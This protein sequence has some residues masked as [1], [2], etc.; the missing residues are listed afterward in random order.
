MK[1]RAVLIN[2]GGK[3]LQIVTP[4]D[5]EFVEEL[6]WVIPYHARHWNAD[7]KVW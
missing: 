4:Y 2:D 6:K 3:F 5:A 7:L 1:P